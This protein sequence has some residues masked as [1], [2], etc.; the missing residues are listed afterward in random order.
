MASVARGISGSSSRLCDLVLCLRWPIARP[1]A[2][3]V[4]FTRRSV[5][6]RAIRPALSQPVRWHSAPSGGSQAYSFE[7]VKKFSEHASPE[8]ILIDVREPAEYEEGYIPGAINI[9]IKSQPDALFLNADD[10]ED[11]FGFAKPQHDKELV[12]YCKA[13]VRSSAAAQLAQ[14]I[15]YKNVKEYRGSWLDWQKQGGKEARPGM[16]TDSI[17]GSGG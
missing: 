16:S 11:R 3:R 9:P 14:Q 6:H 4:H 17:T 13:G 8:R 10:F 15:G 2:P 5:P 7:E 12:F 1:V